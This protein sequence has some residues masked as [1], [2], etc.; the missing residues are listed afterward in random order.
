MVVMW[1]RVSVA[2]AVSGSAIQSHRLFFHF[3][4]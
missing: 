1:Q 2:Y 3:L 4:C